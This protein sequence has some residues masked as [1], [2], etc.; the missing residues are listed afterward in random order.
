MSQYPD[1]AF[2]INQN[3]FLAAGA[4]EVHAVVTLTATAVAGGAPSARPRPPPLGNENVEV[5]IIDCSGSMD[6]P[7][8]KMMAAKEATKVAID[9]LTDGAY[10]AVVA[11]TEGARVVYPTGGQLLRADYQSRAAA[12]DAV[13][14][15]ARQRRHRDGP[16]AGPG[17]RIFDAHPNAIKHAILLTDGKDESET[18]ADLAR[19]IQASIGTFTADCRGIGEDWEVGELRK[20]AEALLGTVGI[21]RDPPG[22]P[23]TSAG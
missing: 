5:I 4:R 22:S 21:V 6:Y 2:E 10:F 13:S 12:K 11:G 7:R 9:T 23:R 14:P 8:T 16:L 1:F 17:R 15:P 3:E 18:P 20:I 19:A